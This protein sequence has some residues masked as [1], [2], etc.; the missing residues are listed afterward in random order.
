MFDR[1]FHVMHRII[2]YWDVP[3]LFGCPSP[4]KKRIQETINRMKA[5]VD[6]LKA[7]SESLVVEIT[8]LKGIVQVRAPTEN[9]HPEQHRSLKRKTTQNQGFY[10]DKDINNP[11]CVAYQQK[12]LGGQLMFDLTYHTLTCIRW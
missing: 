3:A 2:C 5:E 12:N 8:A 10:L 9:N 6:Q 1:N 11:P 7:A 4:E